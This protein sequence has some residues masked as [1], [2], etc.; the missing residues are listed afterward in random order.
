VERQPPAE[1]KHQ[2]GQHSPVIVG[3]VEKVELAGMP[4]TCFSA[5]TSATE[6]CRAPPTGE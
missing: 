1:L 3:I 6:I 2:Y 4:C 5:G